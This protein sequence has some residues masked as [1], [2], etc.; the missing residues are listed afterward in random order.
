MC[1]VLMYEYFTG[2]SVV[3]APF[4]GEDKYSYEY[5]CT[6]DLF[7]F[8]FFIEKLEICTADLFIV[9]SLRSKTFNP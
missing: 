4:G 6:A 3:Y 8:Y 9:R 7:I 1:T 2:T 5:S